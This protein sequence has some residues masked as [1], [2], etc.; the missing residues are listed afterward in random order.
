MKITIVI[1][2]FISCVAANVPCG[3]QVLDFD[4]RGEWRGQ[5]LPYRKYKYM[6]IT[7][8][9]CKSKAFGYGKCRI[10]DTNTPVGEWKQN[11]GGPCDCGPRSRGFPKTCDKISPNRCGDPDLSPP[12]QKLDNVLIIDECQDRS[13]PPDDFDGGGCF[14]FKFSQRTTVHTIAFLDMDERTRPDIKVCFTKTVLI[15]NCDMFFF[16]F[17]YS[18]DTVYPLEREKEIV[19]AVHC[20]QWLR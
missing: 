7:S 10:F 13:E 3:R 5:Y 11:R 14:I 12:G 19:W 9:K 16:S 1:L 6:G 8:L 20:Q 4:S 17:V 18:V 15:L 2:S